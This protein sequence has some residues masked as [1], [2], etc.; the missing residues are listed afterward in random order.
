MG[1]KI[2]EID[3]NERPREK[4]IRYGFDTLSDTEVLAI[5]ISSGTKEMS[6]IDLANLV[7]SKY[8]GLYNT[9]N[10]SFE[11]FTSFKG[12]K[13]A[14]AAKLGA[15]FEIA[16]RFNMYR[17]ARKESE[18]EI[19]SD[20]LFQKYV[21]LLA[22]LDHEIFIVV[23]LNKK[24]KIIFERTLFEGSDDKV[25]FSI[26]DVLKTIISHNGYYFYVIHNHPS[27]NLTPSVQDINLTSSLMSLSKSIGICLLDHLIIARKAYYSFLTGNV[28]EESIE[29]ND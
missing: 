24:R 16:K 12:I 26:R 3:K 28:K 15:V 7:L 18:V 8:G 23:V 2:R 25:I 1:T 17:L 14:T 22:E 11:E 20:Y 19:S 9:I 21:N 6:A 27:G 4:A 10:Q 5:I 29:N 13:K